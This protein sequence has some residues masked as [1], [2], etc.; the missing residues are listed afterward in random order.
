[1]FARLSIVNEA[2]TK[3]PYP[4]IPDYKKTKSVQPGSAGACRE[5]PVWGLVPDMDGAADVA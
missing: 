4:L 3:T 1:M 5:F 2:N